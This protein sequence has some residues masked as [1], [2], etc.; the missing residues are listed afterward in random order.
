MIADEVELIRG[1]EAGLFKSLKR[2]FCITFSEGS[3]LIIRAIFTS[4]EWVFPGQ[5]KHGRVPFNVAVG[6]S[7]IS[8]VYLCYRL[9]KGC[10]LLQETTIDGRHGHW[11][12]FELSDSCKVSRELRP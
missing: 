7:F 5:S 1:D 9:G 6:C 12:A 4:I 10:K 2:R 11:S 3:L 8:R